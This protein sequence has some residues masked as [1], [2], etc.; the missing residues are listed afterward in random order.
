MENLENRQLLAYSFTSF[1]VPG[2]TETHAAG[3]NDAGR[4]VGYYE[5]FIEAIAFST[6][7]ER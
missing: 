6:F 1:D 7:A 4:I 3:I 5:D 2:A